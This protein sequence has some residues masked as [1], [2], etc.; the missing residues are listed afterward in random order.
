MHHEKINVFR[1]KVAVNVHSE[2]RI[3]VDCGITVQR[4]IVHEYCHARVLCKSMTALV[5][6][7]Q[8]VSN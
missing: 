7:V 3:A 2:D 4:C 1:E 6:E 5:A 8:L